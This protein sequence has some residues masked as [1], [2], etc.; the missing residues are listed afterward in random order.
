MIRARNTVGLSLYSESVSIL[1]AHEP[2]APINVENVPSV[3][4]FDGLNIGGITT[5]YQVGLVW[6]EGPYNGGTHVIDFRISFKETTDSDD[7]YTIFSDLYSPTG[8]TVTGLTPSITYDF[9]IQSRNV[10][11]YSDFS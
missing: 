5:A 1:A 8:I 6:V 3:F 11:N 7:F 4:T 9:R 10:I 2:D